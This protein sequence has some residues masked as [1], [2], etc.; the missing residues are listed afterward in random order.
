[1]PKQIE[2]A[3][4]F[5]RDVS[6]MPQSKIGHFTFEIDRFAGGEWHR[7]SP[8]HLRFNLLEGIST[9]DIGRRLKVILEFQEEVDDG[10]ELGSSKV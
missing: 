3:E 5:I 2:Y 10:D 1:M 9:D 7:N 8:V 4:G 6:H